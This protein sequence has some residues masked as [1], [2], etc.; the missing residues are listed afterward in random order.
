MSRYLDIL[1]KVYKDKETL[2]PNI[3]LCLDPGE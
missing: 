2:I 1:N 3:L